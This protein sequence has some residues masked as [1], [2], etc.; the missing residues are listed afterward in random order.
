[1][2]SPVRLRQ[3]LLRSY[4]EFISNFLKDV[5][6]VS[7]VTTSDYQR[8]EEMITE[9]VRIDLLGKI[10]N[11]IRGGDMKMIVMIAK[12]KDTRNAQSRRKWRLKL[13][14]HF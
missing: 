9:E 13:R 7:S 12:G 1:M 10:M 3:F 14:S 11:D 6:S 5:T 2:S 4:T 8:E